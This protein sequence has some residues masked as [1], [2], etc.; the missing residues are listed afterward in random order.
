MLGPDQNDAKK[1]WKTSKVVAGDSKREGINKLVL[2][3]IAVNKELDIANGL[4]E[5]FVNKVAQI[6][7]H[8]PKPESDLL[9]ILKNTPAPDGD[10]FEPFEI[11]E[12]T[13]NKLISQMKK[14]TS[15]GSDSINAVVLSDIYPV[16]KRSLLHLINLSICT[17]IF[18]TLFKSTKISP[19]LKQGK[20]PTYPL[21]HK[22]IRGAIK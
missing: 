13:L 7:A 18:P 22:P 14:T 11:L 1:V 12:P 19:I 16:I 5:A 20:K 21:S 3:G 10:K 4:N 15:C 9:T 17:G 6:K 2:N 8:L